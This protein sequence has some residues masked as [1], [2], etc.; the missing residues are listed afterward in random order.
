MNVIKADTLG[1]C[2]GVRRAVESAEVAL[3]EYKDK[4]VYSLGP[5]IH[6]QNALDDLASKGLNIIDEGSIDKLTENCVVIIRAHG[7][8]PSVKKILEDKNTVI[9]DATCPRVTVSQNRVK[10]FSRQG[11]TVFLTG[12]KGHAEVEGIRG[13]CESDFYCIENLSEAQ[14]VLKTGTFEKVMLLSQTTFSEMEFARIS[15]CFK[16]F[17]DEKNV[18]KKNKLVIINTICPATK[19]RQEALE[20]LSGKVEGII[21]VG[22]KKSANTVRLYQKASSYVT[23]AVHIENASEIPDEFYSLDTVGI[24][25]GASTPDS[26]I[27]K[28]VE[29]LSE[30]VKG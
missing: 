5:L 15:E 17:F 11:Y 30:G 19:Q 6:N 20:K 21:V 13:F 9:I 18:G 29:A 2:M 7:V 8:K 27:D 22:G 4:K 26:V 10:E 14:L 24:T 28:V 23:K 12:D 1:Y 25:A 16:S 3:R